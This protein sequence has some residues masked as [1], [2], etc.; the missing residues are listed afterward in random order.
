[1]VLDNYILL[2]AVEMKLMN[3]VRRQPE[4]KQTSG[5]YKS[6]NSQLVLNKMYLLFLH[7]MPLSLYVQTSKCIVEIDDNASMSLEIRVHVVMNC[8]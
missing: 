2:V 4:Q 6:H 8:M 5:N 1:M 3:D 7:T